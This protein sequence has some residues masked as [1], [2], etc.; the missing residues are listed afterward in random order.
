MGLSR[1]E[2]TAL[3][4][5]QPIEWVTITHPFHPLRGRRL[6]VYSSSR[7]REVFFLKDLFRQGKIVIPRD[8][9][10]KADPDPYQSLSL[11]SHP[12]PLSLPHLLQLIDFLGILKQAK[13]QKNKGLIYDKE[14]ENI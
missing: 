14:Y 9:T 2:I 12:P 5:N 1:A 7:K 13:S 4:E 3:N 8:W 11:T 10:D 6:E